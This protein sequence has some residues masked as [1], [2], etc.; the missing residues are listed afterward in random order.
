LATHQNL[1]IQLLLHALIEMLVEIGTP[2]FNKF[3]LLKKYN[4]KIGPL[5]TGKKCSGY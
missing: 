5:F 1:K 2:F 3:S 4:T